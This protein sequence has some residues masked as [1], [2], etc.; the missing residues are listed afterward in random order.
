MC[1][2]IVTIQLYQTIMI[3]ERNDFMEKKWWH[4][5]IGYQIYPKSFMDS[6][7]DGV[8]DLAGIT[9][10]LDYLQELGINLIWICPIFKSPQADHGYDISDYDAIDEMYGSKEDLRILI[11]EAKKCDIKV[12]LDL[13]VNHSSNE[14]KWFKEALKD[15]EGKYG[16]Y[17]YFKRGTKDAPPNN[18]RG[19]FNGSTW[20][21]VGDENSDLYYL[22]IFTTEQPDLN[23]ENPELRQEVYDMVNRW[24]DFGVAGFRIDAINHIKKDFSYTNLPSDRVDGLVSGIEYFNSTEGIAEFLQELKRET[25]DKYDCFTLG[26]VLLSDE[27]RLHDYINPK[28][29]HFNS[30]FDFSH[31]YHNVL[32]GDYENPIHFFETIKEGLFTSQKRVGNDKFITNVID[33]HDTCRSIDRAILKEH[34]NFYSQSMLVSMNFFLKGIPFIYQGQ[35]I[36]M[37]NFPK[38]KITDFK[39]PTTLRQYEEDVML[40]K[41]ST[42]VFNEINIRSREHSRTPVQWNDCENAGFTTGTPWFDVNPNYKEI[43]AQ[44]QIDD[45]NSLLSYYKKIIA[46]RK[47]YSDDFVYGSFTPIFKHIKGVFGYKRNNIKVINNC[48]SESIRLKIR[49]DEVILTNYN[50]IEY[51]KKSVILKPFQTLIF[52]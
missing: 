8:G 48:T 15:P 47:K 42:D 43:N 20:E 21:K 25:F 51:N 34:Q 13:V 14:H 24:L 44:S 11:D 30:V 12:L 10:K 45:A 33:N 1:M 27:K 26:E 52:K 2:V 41:N 23:W 38:E 9:Q 49:V 19:I 6:N 32:L 17:Y 35:E 18:W 50:E 28:D 29:G 39:D 4:N 40:G 7:G 37:T 5:A 31:T 16:K 3:F 36:G 46:C 22:H